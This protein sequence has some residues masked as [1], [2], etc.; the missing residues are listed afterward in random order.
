MLNFVENIFQKEMKKRQLHM[1]PVSLQALLGF[2]YRCERESPVKYNRKNKNCAEGGRLEPYIIGKISIIKGLIPQSLFLEYRGQNA[3][4]H[5]LG[6][7]GTLQLRFRGIAGSYSGQLIL[8]TPKPASNRLD[9]SQQRIPV[10]RPKG[11]LVLNIRSE[12]KIFP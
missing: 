4:P 5:P 9:G 2:V 7:K 1:W 11:I 12:D 3:A 10:R 6:L 8:A